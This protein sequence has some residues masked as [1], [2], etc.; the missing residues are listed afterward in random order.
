MKWWGQ[1][2]AKNVTQQMGEREW[3]TQTAQVPGLPGLHTTKPQHAPEF[4]AQQVD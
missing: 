4:C 3:R 1:M 2:C